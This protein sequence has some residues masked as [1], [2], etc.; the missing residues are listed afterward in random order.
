MTPMDAAAA[1]ELAERIRE[2]VWAADIA[3]PG[4]PVGRVSISFGVAS[5]VPPESGMAASVLV[6]QADHALYQAKRKG[7]NCSVLAGE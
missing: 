7:R 3:N 5:I 2:E 4:T 1:F 6:A